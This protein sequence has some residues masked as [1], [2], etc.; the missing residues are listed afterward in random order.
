MTLETPGGL[1][2]RELVPRE[3]ENFILSHSQPLVLYLEDGKSFASIQNVNGEIVVYGEGNA[4]RTVNSRDPQNPDQFGKTHTRYLWQGGKLENLISKSH[5]SVC[6]VE[7]K[8]GGN[9]TIQITDLGS[10][11]KTCVSKA[12]RE[13]PTERKSTDTEPP[14]MRSTT[15]EKVVRMLTNI[16]SP[17][18]VWEPVI[19]PFMTDFHPLIAEQSG[20]I[21]SG[22]AVAKTAVAAPS[23]KPSLET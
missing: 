14:P 4:S 22:V 3:P 21:S 18:V 2:F 5:F 13:K 19:S 11:N 20:E 9:V 23:K 1:S 16:E 6:I 8:P 12:D 17:L 7:E 10:T 15:K